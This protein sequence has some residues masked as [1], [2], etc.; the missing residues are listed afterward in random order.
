MV[1]NSWL[2][3]VLL[4]AIVLIS[5]CST[6]IETSKDN[7]NQCNEDVTKALKKEPSADLNAAIK[8]YCGPEKIGD[9]EITVGPIG[10]KSEIIFTYEGNKL[11]RV[12]FPE[13]IDSLKWL[14]ENSDKDAK[15]LSWWDYGAMI[16][17]F[18]ERDVVALSPSKFVLDK[19]YVGNP[20]LFQESGLQ[21]DITIRKI[22]I[23]LT[24]SDPKEAVI[25]MKEYDAEYLLVP[26]DIEA[27]FGVLSDI[28][29]GTIKSIYVD[30][31]QGG[32]T[33][34]EDT[35]SITYKALTNQAI[36]GFKQVY[37]DEGVII[38]QIAE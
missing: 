10:Y 20:S 36:P 37:S 6:F 18:G 35:K 15:V 3:I 19:K 1:S 34:E 23:V 17:I 32:E 2:I 31:L 11:R 27:K 26:R 38:Y 14:K 21:D 13:L 28:A 24:T 29:Y 22:A 33:E 4:C 16:Y 30:R 8:K 7:P 5:G 25:I 9:T 12:Y